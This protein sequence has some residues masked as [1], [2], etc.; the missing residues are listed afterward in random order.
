[1]EFTPKMFTKKVHRVPVPVQC[2]P[3][4]PGIF[5]VGIAFLEMQIFK[6]DEPWTSVTLRNDF[7]LSRCTQLASAP[8]SRHF[9]QT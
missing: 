6:K 7:M 2:T 8:P 4:C 5:V 1:M 9:M 3:F